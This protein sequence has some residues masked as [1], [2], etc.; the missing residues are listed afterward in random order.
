MSRFS[1]RSNDIEIMDDLAMG[2]PVLTQT[3]D[4]LSV[5]NRLLG[6]D[7]VT[8]SAIK[9]ICKGIHRKD[10]I[11]IA[12]LGCGGGDSLRKLA[13]WGRKEG[14]NLQILG[15]DANPN[16]ITYAKE[17]SAAYPEIVYE[18]LDCFSDSFR[19]RQ[20]DLIICSLFL[21][22]FETPVLMN[23]I[24][25]LVRQTNIGLV[26]NDL[27][28]H[29]LAYYSFRLI[30]WLLRASHMIR[31]DGSLSVLKGFSK[32]DISNLLKKCNFT[33]ATMAWKWAFR[34]QVIIPSPNAPKNSLDTNRITSS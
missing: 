14:R 2:G 15:F 3:L 10:L 25:Q 31:H 12:D 30:T 19:S 17:K 18:T 27:H 32:S 22:H 5:I 29:W 20:F 28:R 13:E 24:P 26:I 1:S 9:K 4:Q 11:T 23:W 6:G 8:L 21:H 7:G 34:W 33:Q 16:T